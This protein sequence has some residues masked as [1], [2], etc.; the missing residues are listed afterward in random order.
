M[1]TAA[2]APEKRPATQFAQTAAPVLEKVPARQSPQAVAET[3]AMNLPGLQFEQDW[4]AAREY[5]PA[6]QARHLASASAPVDC[7]AF[8]AGQFTQAVAPVTST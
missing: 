1:Q 2:P 7:T 8:P 5:L 6:T 3:E 4:A